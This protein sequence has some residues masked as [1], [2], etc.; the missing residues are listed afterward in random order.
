M[1]VVYLH[2]NKLVY[3]RNFTEKITPLKK[4]FDVRILAQRFPVDEGGGVQNLTGVFNCPDFEG[5]QGRCRAG[6]P[7]KF[8]G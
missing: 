5:L 2:K 6:W 7:T 1:Q 4:V 3:V 8:V